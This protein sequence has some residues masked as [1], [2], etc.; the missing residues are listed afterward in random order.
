MSAQGALLK[1]VFLRMCVYNFH[2]IFGNYR[3]VLHSSFQLC[4]A[5]TAVSKCS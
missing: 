4:A 2:Y 5:F 3:Y 1:L